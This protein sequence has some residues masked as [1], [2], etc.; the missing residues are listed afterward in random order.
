MKI[1]VLVLVVLAACLRPVLASEQGHYENFMQTRRDLV[2]AIY[3]AHTVVEMRENQTR[4]LLL[5]KSIAGQD[6]GRHGRIYVFTE[7]G[8][9]AH[10][11]VM[12]IRLVEKDGQLLVHRSGLSGGDEAK[13]KKWIDES[14]R[15]DRFDVA[16]ILGQPTNDWLAPREWD[17]QLMELTREYFSARD[18]G[19][20]RTAHSRFEHGIAPFEAWSADVAAF[21]QLAGNVVSR[22]LKKV[23]WYRYPAGPN[24]GIYGAVDF[25]SRFEHIDVHCGHLMWKLQPDGSFKLIREEEGHLDRQTA[26]QLSPSQVEDHV[27]NVLRCRA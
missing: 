23:S 22:T 6:Y 13:F 3:K 27:R 19:E 18:G 20:L 4:R 21:N 7:E 1:Y 9:F 24:E 16:A 5:K 10:P 14:T 25:Q 15:Q 2:D 8:H 12:V 17:E 26:K 11:A